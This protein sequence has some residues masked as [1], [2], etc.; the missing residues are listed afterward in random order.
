VAAP[1]LPVPV[2]LPLLVVASVAR[3]LCGRSFGEHVR[4]EHT[5]I[6]A[7]A[8]VAALVL[9]LIA[10]APLVEAFAG[11]AV[12]WS[13]YPIV[14]GN[15]NALVAVLVIV[16]ATAIASELVLRAWLVERVLELGG[17]VV[18][19]IFVG[20]FAEALVTTG[21]LEARIGAFAFGAALGWMYVAAGRNVAVTISARLAFQVGVVV[22]EAARWVD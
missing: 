17:A 15:P 16:V 19:A 21:P 5:A 10:G 18:P 6:G 12:V 2:A 8:G 1:W 3:W 9:G 11:G 22:L 7:G 4:G 13:D 20:A 14:R